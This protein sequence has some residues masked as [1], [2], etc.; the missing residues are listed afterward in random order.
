MIMC[1]LQENFLPHLTHF[2]AIRVLLL[3]FISRRNPPNRSHRR[4]L[5]YSPAHSKAV[6]WMQKL[7]H[8]LGSLCLRH[9]QMEQRC[10][11]SLQRK[12]YSSTG[13]SPREHVITQSDA[14]PKH[15]HIRDIKQD[16]VN[17]IPDDDLRPEVAKLPGRKRV[18]SWG[19]VQ[20][21]ATP[22]NNGPAPSVK[23]K[24]SKDYV[25]P[26]ASSSDAYSDQQRHPRGRLANGDHT[27]GVTSPGGSGNA[28]NS[29]SAE[30][31][32][33]V[34]LYNQL[35]DASSESSSPSESRRSS[36]SKNRKSWDG[37]RHPGESEENQKVSRLE[38]KDNKE[39]S[40]SDSN[41]MNLPKEQQ[42]V[43]QAKHRASQELYELH[44]QTKT[45]NPSYQ[46][47]GITL[48]TNRVQSSPKMNGVGES[49]F[50]VEVDK[51]SGSLGL[52][53]EGGT[54]TEDDVKIKSVKEG[55][56]A[57]W[58][59]GTLK[60]GQVLLQVDDKPLGGMTSGIAVL[61]L[62]QA[63]SSPDSAVLKLLVRDV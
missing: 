38:R 5:L 32:T 63:Y 53:L 15:D 52:T 10:L 23:P 62:R 2:I 39:R 12:Q 21:D 3:M 14:L 9:R 55:N 13:G 57:A 20:E 56:F 30:V 59:C 43:I 17:A 61:T 25:A 34:H 24:P 44:Q 40:C 22:V 4:I 41:L 26:S 60:A 6:R 28:A 8:L 18:A 36:V 47:R 16:I 19:T 45:A 7:E 46:K 35:S 29:N 31:Q 50:V 11:N 51:S 27:D 48:E 33:K 58:K 37:V 1:A 49:V 42:K 54:D